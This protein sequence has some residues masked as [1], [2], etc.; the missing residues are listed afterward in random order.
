MIG[1]PWRNNI[2]GEGE[3]GHVRPHPWTMDGEEI[4]ANNGEAVDVVIGV[5]YHLAG[6]FCGG[7]ERGGTRIEMLLCT[8]FRFLIVKCTLACA[9]TF[10]EEV[11]SSLSSILR[12]E[13][14]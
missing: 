1:L 14:I 5:G 2:I 10:S 7:V 4:E 8:E 11:K 3:V 12:R 6:F 13:Q 9:A